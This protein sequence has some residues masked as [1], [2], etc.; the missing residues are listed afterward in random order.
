MSSD[1]K[2]GSE[3]D[4]SD[5]LTKSSDTSSTPKKTK[6]KEPETLMEA[7]PMGLATI[8]NSGMVYYERLPM[9]EV[10]FDRLVRLLTTS[11][12]NLTG[13]NVEISLESI[14]SVRF[15]DYVSSI[16][17][18]SMINI[19]IAEEWD[20]H[21]IVMLDSDLIYSMVDVLLG[22]RKGSATIRTEN[23]HYTT[24]E[25]SLIEKIVQVFLGDL[26]AAFDPICPITLRFERLETN[27]KFASI[28]RPANAA[29]LVRLSVLV[30]NR[31]GCIELVLPYATLEPIRE[32]L[33]Q[34]FMGE[35]FGRDTI[36]ENHLAGELY[37]TDFELSA[38]LDQITISLHEVL[39]WEV[40]SQ[41][42][43][44]A[45][46]TTTVNLLCGEHPLFIGQ[47]GRKKGNIAVKIDNF[48]I[49][50]EGTLHVNNY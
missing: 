41:I 3:T 5:I 24:I 43:L 22:C 40:G 36:W 29:V 27:S 30:D 32:L 34:N 26:S 35:K 2:R 44:N 19:F 4:V 50:E 48:I 23:R 18:P 49:P 8:L 46:P 6:S 25:I 47:V 20:N 15:G 10:V 1:D 28:A 42:F 12:R 38:L 21:G 17:Q 37:F 11:M 13:D 7:N 31:G 14:T 16:P 45:T 33:L 9:L 39:M